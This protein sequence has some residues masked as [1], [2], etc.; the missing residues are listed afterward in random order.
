MLLPLVNAA[1]AQQFRVSVQ[2]WAETRLPAVVLQ[3]VGALAS[4]TREVRS[5]ARTQ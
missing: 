2:L 4:V 3:L 5:I 1:L